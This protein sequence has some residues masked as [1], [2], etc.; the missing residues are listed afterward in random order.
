MPNWLKNL[1]KESPAPF[2]KE[3]G[4]FELPNGIILGPIYFSGE[5]NQSNALMCPSIWAFNYGI[6]NSLN[7]LNS[8]SEIKPEEF[9]S[10]FN[11]LLDNLVSEVLIYLDHR[12]QLL[13]L[14]SELR[15]NSI[16]KY[17]ELYKK[18]TDLELEKICNFSFFAALDKVRGEKHH[19]HRRY[20]ANYD[21]SGTKYDTIEKLRNLI[22]Q[23]K[24]EIQNLDQQLAI[25]HKDYDVK[26]THLPTAIRV[27]WFAVK[28][29]FDM[30]AGGKMVP[31]KQTMGLDSRQIKYFS[32][33]VNYKK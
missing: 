11:S 16:V 8:P 22:L 25:K 5:G 9:Q 24:K 17:V 1:F 20:D 6:T 2:R 21:I 23:T 27:E 14:G 30:T 19:S 7:Q 28:H 18:H 32:I 13:S 29:A 33:Q 4:G 31:Q 12:L 3:A 26:I 15:K 10:I